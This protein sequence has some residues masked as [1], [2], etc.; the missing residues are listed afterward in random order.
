MPCSVCGSLQDYHRAM[1]KGGHES[2]D[3]HLP[4]A[5]GKLVTVKEVRPDHNGSS[6]VQQCAECDA[7]FLYKT[8][9]EFLVYGSEDEQ[10][11]YRISAQQADELMRT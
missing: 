1:Q 11:L 2:Q 3:T 9:Y 5:S 10:Q 8:T 6:F 7:W 4:A